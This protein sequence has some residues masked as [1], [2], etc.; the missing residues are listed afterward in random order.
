MFTSKPARSRIAAGAKLFMVLLAMAG[1]PVWVLGQANPRGQ[2]PASK[3]AEVDQKQA[4]LQA[5]LKQLQEQILEN[6]K[7]LERLGAETRAKSANP[8]PT[9]DADAKLIK[10]VEARIAELSK[11]LEEAKRKDGGGPPK[12]SSP[13]QLKLKDGITIE[14]DFEFFTEDGKPPEA[15]P[16]AKQPPK[17]ELQISPAQPGWQM[18]KGRLGQSPQAPTGGPQP[19]APAY[20]VIGPDGKEI[21]GATVVPLSPQGAQP[22]ASSGPSPRDVEEAH[23]R[24]QE[25]LQGFTREI[26]PTEAK[27]V[28]VEMH[29]SNPI[30]LS[31]ATYQ[32]PKE[33]AEALTAFLK[34]NV[35][36]P[37]LEFKAEG[38]GVTI[39]TSPEAQA[40]IGGI[41]K[42]MQGPEKSSIRIWEKK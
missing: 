12:K 23:K 32:L 35:R 42:L 14:A 36:A 29:S 41:V 9:S 11:R 21:K 28:R 33:K 22:G 25:M 16:G 26:K 24:L 8:A 27:M 19:K 5:M 10:D 34:A 1:L 2:P 39:T 15:K 13:L 17:Y 3:P 20:K 40:T 7:R 6:S 4:E 30:A 38:E 31:R 37:V 18:F